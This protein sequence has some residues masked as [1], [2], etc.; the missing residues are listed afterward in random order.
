METLIDLF[1]LAEPVIETY[2]ASY[3]VEADSAPSDAYSASGTYSSPSMHSRVTLDHES[4]YDY[5][6]APRAAKGHSSE[7][8]VRA[9]LWATED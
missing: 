7:G 5:G 9:R 2:R 4:E 6:S 3:R 1:E 8:S